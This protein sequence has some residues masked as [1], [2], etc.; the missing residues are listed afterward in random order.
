M[1]TQN[2]QLLI[3]KLDEFIRKYYKNLL[4]KGAIYSFALLL[5]FFITVA[6]LEYF[7]HFQSLTRTILFYAFV[8]ISLLIIFR[9]IVI[10]LLKL[11]RLGEII[12]YEEAAKIIGTH[13][14]EVEDRLLNVLQ[15]Q[16]KKAQV[17]T[18][19]LSLLE[20]S[21]N[22]KAEQLKPLP[23]DAAIDLKKN[24]HYVPYAA[25]PLSILLILLI[26]RPAAI[27]ESTERLVKYDVY[28]EKPAP[29]KFFIENS[30]LSA[31]QQEDFE[32]VVSIKGDETP[33][34][35]YI[36]IGESSFKLDKLSPIKF[37]YL[38]KNVQENIRFTLFANEVYSKEFELKV[39][40][41]P[42]LLDFKIELNY[43]SYI[44]KKNEVIENSG[45][46]TIP[47]GTKVKWIFT[48][49]NAQALRI[50]FVDTSFNL[51][52]NRE[53]EFMFEQR[54]LKSNKYTLTTA[55]QFVKN[56]DV[57]S[58]SINVI[59]DAYPEIELEERIDS[60][61]PKRLYFRGNI[62]D[63]Y[64]FKNLSFNIIHTKG[65]SKEENRIQ[66]PIAI[67]KKATRQSFF[68]MFDI[69]EMDIQ[70]GDIVEYYFEVFDNDGVNGSKSSRSK[71]FIYKAPTK[72][73]I[74]EQA[75][76]NN[77]NI[78]SSLE[79]ALQEAKVLQ[80]EINEINK[81]MIEKQNLDWN[82]KK[83]MQDLLNKQKELQQKVEDIIR[84]TKQN[85]NHQN[86]YNDLSERILEKQKQL[87]EIFEKVMNEEMKELF[88]QMEKLMEQ[89]NKE[90][91]KE[92]NEQLKISNKD[93]EKE[94]DR[95]LELFKRL[96]VEQ[97][98]QESID[99]L[100]ELAQEQQKLSEQSQQKNADNKQLEQKQ[101]E[102][103]K[104]FEDLKKQID[105]AEKKNNELEDPMNLPNTDQ[106][107][108]EIQQQMENSTK[109]LQ[110]KNNKKASE[111]Q[112]NAAQKMQEMAN[113]MDMAMQANEQQQNEE[114]MK[115]LRQILEN[116][117]A[118]SF[119]QENIMLE[120]KKTDKNNPQYVKLTQQQKK[121][122]DDAKVAE[123][124]LLALSKRVPQISATINKE[125]SAIH[126]NMDKALE[127]LGERQ[128]AMATARQQ[129]VMTS[130][131]N[132]A[133]L[134]SEA[135]KQMQQ[136]AAQQKQGQGSCSKPG[137][138]GQSKSIPKP[139]A[140]S[141][142]KMQEQ[143]NQQIQKLKE[144][145]EKQGGMP[146][147]RSQGRSS[148]SEDL[149][150]AAAQQEAIRQQLRK[151]AEELGKQGENGKPGAGNLDKLAKMMEETE[152]DLV[153]KQITQETLKRQQE[154]LTKLLEAEK[155]EREREFDEKRQSNE[156][157]NQ[158]F[159]NPEQFFEYKRQKEKEAE[160][161]KTVPV[162]LLPFY[163][164]KVNEYFN[165][166]EE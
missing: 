139:S 164:N 82:D 88:R 54:F 106:Q 138:G 30:E 67:D 18:A 28:F 42:H 69:A 20:A 85:F 114:D 161:L 71:T 155:A 5:S 119:Q 29:F 127:F 77:Q 21:I 150:K 58:Y 66:R 146:K 35:A 47:A 117:L 83:K 44:G 1:A 17:S 163:K 22:Q 61:S 55:N 72:K 104:Q 92:L 97:K 11:Y 4:L 6:L 116:L 51:Q 9:Y 68:Y 94:L 105:D 15:L 162:T 80:K 156:A 160:L 12:S 140:Q 14:K 32:L 2:F 33:E 41:Y 65:E 45:D 48:T 101:N 107:E 122:K 40:P 7:G 147:G 34:N 126:M 103:N 39:L 110:N 89:L 73:E 123:D 59:P 108:K 23:F 109:E 8:S 90:K 79:S 63:D 87:E 25:I 81:R 56:K 53:N 52:P 70:P 134:L 95:S 76:K 62:A 130:V 143:I 145:L 148:L 43:P 153:N 64:G 166:L 46:L 13:F 27:T 135:L 57:I 112:K 121:I 38:F 141:M 50:A 159:S 132:L 142:R 120:L 84:Q 158:N 113:Q 154:I 74:Q 157:K 149:A 100:K 78:K 124:S 98:I 31:I 137:G 151:L 128:T 86:Q 165:K 16:Q 99:K 24:L 36:K 91:L 152:K 131:N 111:S 136:Q 49:R 60:L 96:E 102:L 133:L 125:I 75:E 93:L 115:T 37:S 19:S 118:I 144:Q 26:F 3:E 129:Y 10:P